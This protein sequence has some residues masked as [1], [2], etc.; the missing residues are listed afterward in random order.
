MPA[1]NKILPN[2]SFGRAGGTRPRNRVPLAGRFEKGIG[3]MSDEP[4]SDNLYFTL[5]ERESDNS[6]FTLAAILD[7]SWSMARDTRKR[8]DWRTALLIPEAQQVGPLMIEWET[9]EI[10]AR[11]K[12]PTLA[13]PIP[14]DAYDSGL[15]E[16]SAM[17]DRL[18]GIVMGDLARFPRRRLVGRLIAR[19]NELGIAYGAQPTAQTADPLAEL[20][21]TRHENAG[22][23]LQHIQ[24]ARSEPEVAPRNP[25]AGENPLPATDS[26]RHS[27]DSRSVLDWTAYIPAKRCRNTRI[28]THKQLIALLAKVPNNQDGIR[29]A[30]QGQ[31]LYVH[32]GD[33]DRW[34]AEQ[35][36]QQADA[37][38]R[39]IPDVEK[40]KAEIKT[41][42]IRKK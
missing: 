30:Y 36:R 16:A 13:I 18:I 9:C 33:W 41:R 27:L 24:P 19:L 3:T 1:A 2:R 28:E 15:R 32:A 39:S 4:A 25:A 37:L 35:D 5:D 12:S 6:Y 10:S 40:V 34:N 38:D 21:S 8:P 17:K 11:E 20:E 14:F 42:N 31:H 29:R 23:S 26:T 22:P 7:K